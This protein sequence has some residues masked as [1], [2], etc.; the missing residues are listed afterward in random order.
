MSA[1]LLQLRGAC[2][3]QQ[4]QDKSRFQFVLRSRVNCTSYHFPPT[5]CG[6]RPFPSSVLPSILPSFLPF[7]RFRTLPLRGFRASPLRGFR[8]SPLRGFRASP[9]RGFRALPIAT[10]LKPSLAGAPALPW[11]G[12]HA[13]PSSL[14][15]FLFPHAGSALVSCAGSARVLCAGSA[16]CHLRGFFVFPSFRI[17][18]LGTLEGYH[19][20]NRR[21]VPYRLGSGPVGLSGL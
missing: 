15:P 17:W 3:Q 9:W 6:F 21:Q 12:L 4:S 14:L 5:L 18:G 10:V 16:P 1:L 8:A 11:H 20:S 2:K 13:L 7:C 19:C